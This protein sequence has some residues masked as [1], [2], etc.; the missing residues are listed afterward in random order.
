MK[1]L[2]TLSVALLSCCLHP[3]PSN[4]NSSSASNVNANVSPAATQTLTVVDT[5][6]RVK[7]MMA[8]RGEQDQAQPTLKILEPRQTRASIARR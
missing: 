3:A 7:D 8:S 5:P 6:Q 1:S 2:A 4:N